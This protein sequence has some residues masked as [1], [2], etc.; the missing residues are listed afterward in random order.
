LPQIPLPSRIGDLRASLILLGAVALLAVAGLAMDGNWPKI[1]RVSTSFLTYAV[2]LLAAVGARR[3]TGSFA[4]FRFRAFALAGGAS[5]LVSGLVRPDVEADLV[6]A[7]VVAGALLLG[8]FHWLALI[9]WRRLH[10]LA[11]R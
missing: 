3:C 4:P 8:G 5:G 2:V 11:T 7:G 6:G 10:S 9:Q 1:A